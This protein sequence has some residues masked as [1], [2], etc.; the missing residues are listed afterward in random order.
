VLVSIRERPVLRVRVYCRKFVARLHDKLL[1]RVKI[2]QRTPASASGGLLI[3][4]HWGITDLG[5][6]V[7]MGES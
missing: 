4:D 7:A 3:T 5:A 2:A 1:R 6:G